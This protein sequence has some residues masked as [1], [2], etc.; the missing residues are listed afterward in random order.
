MERGNVS[1]STMRSGTLN[2]PTPREKADGGG[3]DKTHVRPLAN[4]I[5]LQHLRRHEQSL[6]HVADSL[7]ET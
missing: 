1:Y 5:S 6:R 7:A 3:G 4:N 2:R